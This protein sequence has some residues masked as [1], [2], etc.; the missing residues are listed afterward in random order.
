[1]LQVI[2]FYFEYLAREKY[3][4]TKFGFVGG[5]LASFLINAGEPST[6][7]ELMHG[8]SMCPQT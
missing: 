1:M 2:S 5:C 8:N 7:R 6:P 3:A 4:D